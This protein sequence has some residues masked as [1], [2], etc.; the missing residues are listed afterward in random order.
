MGLITTVTVTIRTHAT[1]IVDPCVR[2][3]NAAELGSA[4]NPNVTASITVLVLTTV[5]TFRASSVLQNVL[6]KCV[7]ATTLVSGSHFTT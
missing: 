4:W 5:E 1:P 6:I 3:V 2:P 7:R